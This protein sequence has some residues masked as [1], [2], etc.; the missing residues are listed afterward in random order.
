VGHAH[1]NFLEILGG[2]G[3]F[4]ALAWL[5]WWAGVLVLAWR[6]R[7]ISEPTQFAL[8]VLAAFFVFHLNGLTQVNFWEAKVLHQ[9]TFVIAW[10]LL[11]VRNEG[12]KSKHG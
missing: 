2:T 11:W 4:G 1:N 12:Y 10:V 7:K 6:A 8:G 3:L 5:A 9:L